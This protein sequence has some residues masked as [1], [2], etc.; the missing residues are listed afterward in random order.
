[1]IRCSQEGEKKVYEL[2]EL[3]GLNKEHLNRYPH[4]LSGGQV[5]RAVLA[6]ILSLKPRFVVVDEPTS[7]LDVSVQA[8]VL[9]LLKDIQKMFN[10]AYLFI[11][12]DLDVVCWMSD[13]MAIMYCGDIVEIGPA[14]KV[15]D[16]PLHPYTKNLVQA[17]SQFNQGNHRTEMRENSQKKCIITGFSGCNFYPRCPLAGSACGEKPEL[18]KAGNGHLVACHNV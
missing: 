10:I 17:F 16:D 8:Q 15:Y 6:R 5:Q 1:V 12:H 3:V 2:I 11:S 9:N 13:R 14:E 7:M 18:K 4:E